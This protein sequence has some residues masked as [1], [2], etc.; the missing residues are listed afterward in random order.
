MHTGCNNHS[1]KYTEV[2]LR[3]HSTVCG[4]RVPFTVCFVR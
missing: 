1:N 3:A 2:V 4:E